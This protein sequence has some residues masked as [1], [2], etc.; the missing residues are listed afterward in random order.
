MGWRP[1]GGWGE[2][3]GE[4]EGEDGG[5]VSEGCCACYQTQQCVEVGKDGRDIEL[6]G[7]HVQTS[8]VDKLP[9]PPNG[10]T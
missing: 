8:A 4:G 9:S 3:E 10:P 2:L 6:G 1:C 7:H 5:T